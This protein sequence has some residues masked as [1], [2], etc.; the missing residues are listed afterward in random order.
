M[1]TYS[2]PEITVINNELV[3]IPAKAHIHSMTIHNINKTRVSLASW[4]TGKRYFLNVT[5]TFSAYANRKISLIKHSLRNPFLAPM[6]DDQIVDM[7]MHQA[8]ESLNRVKSEMRTSV[9]SMLKKI[10]EDSHADIRRD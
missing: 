4:K 6:T 9:Q 5:G 3:R 1:T 8:L 2:N 7:A 10:E